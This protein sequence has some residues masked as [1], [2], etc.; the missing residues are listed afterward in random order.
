[1]KELA[2]A[3]CFFLALIIVWEPGGHVLK[4]PSIE[5]VTSRHFKHEA[6]HPGRGAA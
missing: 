5:G 3:R 4:P 6:P 2:L 1:M